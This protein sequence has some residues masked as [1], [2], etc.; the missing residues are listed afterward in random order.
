LTDFGC[1]GANLMTWFNN[2]ERPISVTAITQTIKP[3]IY[4]DVDD[5]ATILLTY[6][7][8]ARDHTGLMELANSKKGY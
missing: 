6:K 3:D 4:P 7:K 5:E 1:Y 8:N 2:G